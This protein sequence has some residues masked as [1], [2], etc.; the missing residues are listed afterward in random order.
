M[1]ELNDNIFN[2]IEI[3]S[4]QG[5]LAM[6]RGEYKL[7]IFYFQKALDIIP[8]PKN[9]WESSEWLYASLGDAYFFEEKYV[10]ACNSFNESILISQESTSSFVYL[11][12]GESFFE[13]GDSSKASEYLLRAYMLDG[14]DIFENEPKKYIN[15]IKHL[16]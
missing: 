8:N 2:E 13:I 4:E 5:N 11:R 9:D 10:D 3:L 6:E 15:L 12:M 14:Y 16:I 1:K 7:G